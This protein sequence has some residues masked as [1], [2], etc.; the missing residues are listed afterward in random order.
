[1]RDWLHKMNFHELKLPKGWVKCSFGDIAYI[2]NGYAFKSINF[3]KK[4]ELES[5]VPLVKQSQ[6]N[7]DKVD[8]SSAVYLEDSFLEKQS[9]YKLSKGDV[10]IGL[11]GSIGKLCIYDK[12]YPAL[13]NQRTGKI[14]QYIDGVINNKFFWFFLITI[15]QK[16]VEKSKGVGVQNISSKEIE[17]Q[18]FYLPPLKEQNRIVQAVEELF[19][20]LDKGIETLY[21]LQQQLKIYRYSVLKWAFE[22]KLT[23]KWREDQ[24]ELQNYTVLLQEIKDDREEQ[25]KKNGKKLKKYTPPTSEELRGLFDLPESWGWS[26][27]GEVSDLCLGKMLDKKKN[28][29]TYQY[30]LGNI[31]VRWNEFD[32]SNLQQMRFEENEDERYGIKKGDLIICEGGEPGRAAIWNDQLSNMKIQKALHRVRLHPHISNKF[33]L[34]FLYYCSKNGQLNRY[35][36]GTTIKHFPGQKL[37]VFLFPLCSIEEQNQ[38]IEDLESR[39]SLCD[40][41][42]ETIKETLIQS[43]YLRH[44]ILKKAF[45]GKLVPQDPND[46]PAED[47]LERIRLS[48][49]ERNEKVKTRKRKVKK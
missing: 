43:G 4:K 22:G 1:M 30:Y 40:K 11:S 36:T 13:Q 15:E 19:S 31:N 17:A 27:L 18:D 8:L 41:L 12:D 3:K 45:E 26:K 38:I 23:E 39:L 28:K 35:F 2:R 29:G 6:L 24:Q 32:I 14:E 49:N 16:L 5:D 9:D 37:E 21:I 33:I 47:L 7:G 10:L 34:Y 44:S 42:E 48:K 20:E 25:S 46:E